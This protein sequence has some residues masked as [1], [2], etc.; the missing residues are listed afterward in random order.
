[1]NSQEYSEEQKKDIEERVEKARVF[2]KELQLRPSVAVQAV[3][4][5]DDVF[6]LKSI[7]FLQDEKFTLTKSPLSA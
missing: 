4:T 6:A 5:G 3:N 1:M 7:P 2:L